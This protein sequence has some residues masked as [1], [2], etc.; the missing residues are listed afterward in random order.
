[1]PNVL[2][3]FEGSSSPCQKIA[4]HVARR[5]RERSACARVVRIE[6]ISVED[7]DWQDAAIVVV[8]TALG[9]ATAVADGFLRHRAHVLASI[10]SAILVVD[11]DA[12][13]DDPEVRAGARERAA[14]LVERVGLVPRV[15]SVV[16][17]LDPVT[18]GGAVDTFATR[19]LDGLA[20]IAPSIRL[21][22]S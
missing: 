14:A 20:G 9:R 6:G 17:A 16:G 13:S 15:V 7:F 21:V 2:V 1:M 3:V 4:L 19:F 5:I 12:T 18:D 11:D 8:A 22:R 10:P